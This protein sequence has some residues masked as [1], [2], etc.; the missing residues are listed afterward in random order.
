MLNPKAIRTISDLRENPLG[1]I[2]LAEELGEP[3]YLF[4]RATPKG[5]FMDLAQYQ[6]MRTLLEDYHD[7]VMIKETIE[8]PNATWIPWEQMKK[9]LARKKHKQP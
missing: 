7:A 9:D 2:K 1:V 3:I 5:V 6:Q 8:D 4:N